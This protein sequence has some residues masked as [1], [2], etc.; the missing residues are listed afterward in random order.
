MRHKGLLFA[1]AAALAALQALAPAMAEPASPDNASAAGVTV[2]YS[3]PSASEA[4]YPLVSANRVLRGRQG[5]PGELEGTTA[6]VTVRSSSPS[7]SEAPY[8]LVPADVVLPGKE[9]LPR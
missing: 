3:G 8:P 4:P 5:L 2:R 9:G 6:E 1:A 7:A